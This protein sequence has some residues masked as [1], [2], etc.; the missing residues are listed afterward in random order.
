MHMWEIKI[1][2]WVSLLSSIWGAIT[3]WNPCSFV[4]YFQSKVKVVS[5]VAIHMWSELRD[6]RLF[7]LQ[8]Y[9]IY[10]NLNHAHT[11]AD[12]ILY[13]PCSEPHWYCLKFLQDFG[14]ILLM[15]VL[16]TRLLMKLK[17]KYIERKEH[18]F[19]LHLASK[20][21]VFFCF[22]LAIRNGITII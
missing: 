14:L 5:N 9:K 16:V 2:S 12:L 6:L 20:T 18:L 13:S 19:T 11:G 21:H 4:R 10:C 17:V 1:R 15:V 7:H 3:S 8:G 22:P